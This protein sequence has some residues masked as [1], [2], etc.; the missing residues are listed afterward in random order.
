MEKEKNKK[1]RKISMKIWK[2]TDCSR[3]LQGYY[4]RNPNIEKIG[5]H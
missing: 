3:N 1:I 5:G 2:Q 4:I